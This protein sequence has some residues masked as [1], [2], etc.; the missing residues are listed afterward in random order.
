M[1]VVFRGRFYCSDRF[2][3]YYPHVFIKLNLLEYVVLSKFYL[4]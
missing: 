3:D 4:L 2:K 1:G